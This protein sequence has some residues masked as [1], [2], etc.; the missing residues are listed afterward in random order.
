MRVNFK[1]P[2]SIG[3]KDYPKGIHTVPDSVEKDWYFKAMIKAGSAVVVDPGGIVVVKGT[4]PVSMPTK[5]S[6]PVEAEASQG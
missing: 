4:K 3:G 2:R 5:K 1:V 6:K